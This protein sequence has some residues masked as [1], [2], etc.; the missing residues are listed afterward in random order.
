MERES[1]PI[2]V[3]ESTGLTVPIFA[4][5]AQTGIVDLGHQVPRMLMDQAPVIVQKRPTI[6][7]F[8]PVTVAVFQIDLGILRDAES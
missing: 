3:D 2:A 5:S 7:R 4:G 1:R 6:I 8:P